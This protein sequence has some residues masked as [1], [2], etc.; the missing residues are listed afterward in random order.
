M[1]SF[2][3]G[4]ELVVVAFH[5]GLLAGSPVP[6]IGLAAVQVFFIVSG[7]Y[8]AMVLTGA[9]GFHL[10]RGRTPLRL[11]PALAVVALIVPIPTFVPG[12]L[13]L[14]LAVVVP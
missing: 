4:L 9:C 11:L 14:A 3:L 8:M 13:A 5:L 10:A 1:G 2:R 12:P 7:F 6:M